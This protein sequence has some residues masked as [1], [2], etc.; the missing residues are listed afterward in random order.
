[1]RKISIMFLVAVSVVFMG[2]EY[3]EHKIYRIKTESGE[4]ICL[5]CPKLDPNQSVFSYFY[6]KE[7]YVVDENP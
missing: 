6:S 4:T 7:C 1:M 5:S 2:C 3:K